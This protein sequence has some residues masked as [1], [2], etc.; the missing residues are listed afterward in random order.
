M[1]LNIISKLWVGCIIVIIIIILIPN[2]NINI[3]SN[4]PL[5]NQQEVYRQDEETQTK[6]NLIKSKFEKQFDIWDGSHK[7]LVK[8]VKGNLNDD[9]S[10]K[11]VKTKYM[12]INSVKT[13][14]IF[15]DYRAKNGF[16]AYMLGHIIA[17]YDSD[18][19]LIEIIK[20]KE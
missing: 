20:S 13:V 5:K 15:M 2:D 8:M 6:E 3:N 9:E 17:D 16:G 19:N 1:K 12:F 4:Q 11:H 14:R 18:E 10:F 7:A